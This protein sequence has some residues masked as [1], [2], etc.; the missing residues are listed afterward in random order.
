VPDHSGGPHRS[1]ELVEAMPIESAS[2]GDSGR[3]R[4]TKTVSFRTDAARQAT[5][6]A[7]AATL[8]AQSAAS[9]SPASRAK[10]KAGAGA[11]AVLSV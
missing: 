11:P 5:R 9:A 6:S 10:R 1:T 2:S 7:L 4:L 3:M 8:A